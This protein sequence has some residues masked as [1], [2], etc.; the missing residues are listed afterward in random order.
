LERLLR[1]IATACQR[2]VVHTRVYAPAGQLL[3]GLSSSDPT[4]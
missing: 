3:L 2:R 1:D 4:L